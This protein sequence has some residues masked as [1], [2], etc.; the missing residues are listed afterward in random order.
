MASPVIAVGGVA[1]DSAPVWLKEFAIRNFGTNDKSVLLSGIG[2][3]LAVYA[4]VVGLVS[5]RSLRAGISGVVLFVA[6]GAAAAITRPGA[7]AVNLV[8][9]LVGG[10]VGVA[11]LVLLVRAGTRTRTRPAPAD[12]ATPTSAEPVVNRW[13]R[14]A[15]LASGAGVA[16]LA[17]AGGGI[18]KLLARRAGVE[19]SRAAVRLPAPASK[20]TPLPAGTDLRLPGLTPFTTANADFYRVDTALIVPQVSTADW[21]LRVHGMVDHELNLDFDQLLRRPMVERDITLTCVSNEVGGRYAGSARWIGVPLRD[22]LE[23]AGVH[24]GSNQLVSR[25]ADG[26]TAGSPV[27]VVMDGRDALLA[28]GMNGQ[29][30]PIE[31]GFPVRMIVPGLYGYV[32]ATKWLV[33]L[34]LTTF[35]AFDSYWTQRK[36]APNGP[37][38]TMAR[39]DTPKPLS[40]S[41]KGTLA[42]AGVAWAQHRG[43]DKVEVRV[44]GGPWQQATLAAVPTKDTWRQ[45]VWEWPAT[46]GRHT[47][48]ARATDGTGAVQTEQRADPFPNGASGWHSVVVSVS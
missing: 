16:V 27:S 1:I 48:E 36:W 20:A 14:R 39:I 11:A 29:P 45:W 37:I 3:T 30:L 43:I 42:V 18:A 6:L 41:A 44:D 28:V 47:L 35:D 46:S 31:H 15:F 34:E 10:L 7:S 13:D 21:Q 25:S 38:K 26:W 9:S 17:L 24:S 12:R 40:T 22:L 8:P 4:L 33:D 23:E 19:D 32:S 2:V 5:Y